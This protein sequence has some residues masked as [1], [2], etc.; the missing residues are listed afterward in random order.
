MDRIKTLFLL[1]TIV[2]PMHMAEQLMTSIEEFYAIRRLLETTYYTWFDP[3]AADFATVILVTIVWTTG[4][5]IFYTLLVGGA[6]R[7]ILLGVFGL[8]GALEVHHVIQAL[9]NGAYDPGV[10]TSVPY[11]ALGC[12]MVA[13]VWREF[14][15]AASTVGAAE[16][17]FA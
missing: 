2:G 10:I 14:K 11:S 12:L 1:L 6:P 16:T 17:T 3:S 9:V 4:S 7:L 15:R 13:A 8:F 5:L